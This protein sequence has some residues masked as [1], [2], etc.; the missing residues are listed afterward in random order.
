MIGSLCSVSGTASVV[1]VGNPKEWDTAK[2]RT[3]EA[4]KGRLRQKEVR[5]FANHAVL[6]QRRIRGYSG[7]ADL[8]SFSLHRREGSLIRNTGWLGIQNP[9]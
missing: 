4:L 9:V 6:I 7:A 5:W 8:K 2:D 3:W 1:L